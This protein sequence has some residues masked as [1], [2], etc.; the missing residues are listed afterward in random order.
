MKIAVIGAGIVGASTAYHLAHEGVK[1]VL[2]DRE[3]QGQATAAGAGIVC[4]W[5]SRRRANQDWSRLADAGA[6]Y[7]S[8]LAARLRK[9]GEEALGYKRVGAIAVSNDQAELD[10]IEKQAKTCQKAIPEVGDISW[11]TPEEARK[12]FPPLRSDLEAV[13]VSGGARVDGRL[14]SSALA[15]AAQ[16]YGADYRTGDAELVAGGQRV[17]GV[18][19]NDEFIA[20][21]A[22]VVAAGAWSPALLRPFGLT[23]PVEP[24]RG[25]IVHLKLPGTNTAQWP[26]VVP[27]S[28][29]Y[30][31]AFD[32]SR[33]VVG[34]TRETGS[35]F[36]YRVTASGLQEVLSEALSVAPGLADGTVHETRVG[37]RPMSEDHL[38]FLGSISEVGGVVIATGLGPSGLTIGPYMGRLAAEIVRGRQPEMDLSAYAPLRSCP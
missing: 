25:Q 11:L 29:H 21:D 9:D 31:L 22:V 17:S 10:Q 5:I 19:V 36:D 33:V 12:L 35:G 30:L 14:F 13:Y 27:P 23:L 20:A 16:K 8:S 32:D 7:Y 26:I 4:P 6:Q 37:F 18:R 1:V 34:A 28:S 24:Q 38:P 3:D 2:I 15:R